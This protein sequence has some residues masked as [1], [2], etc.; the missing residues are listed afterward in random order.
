MVL[1][2]IK[3]VGG[4][5]MHRLQLTAVASLLSLFAVACGEPQS[6]IYRESD[7]A[8]TDTETGAQALSQ[9]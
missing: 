7:E 2:S 3:R 8:V 9:G 6:T 5:P 1:D 4:T